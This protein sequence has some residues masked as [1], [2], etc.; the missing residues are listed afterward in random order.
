MKLARLINFAR[1]YRKPLAFVSGLMVIE[2][3]VAL[4]LPWLAGEFA[5]SI[6]AQQAL[7]INTVLGGI[8]G[9][10]ALRSV[11]SYFRELLLVDTSATIIADI[12]QKIYDHIQSLPLGY[13]RARRQ[14]DILSFAVY[15]A[16]EIS[17]Y[18]T[19]TVTSIVPNLLAALGAVIIMAAIDP[20]LAGI[21]L[22]LIPF[23]YIGLR[24]IGR[25]LRPLSVQVRDAYASLVS[26]V[27]E[28]FSMM[29]AIKAYTRE[30]TSSADHLERAQSLRLLEIQQGR[31]NAL[32][33][34][35][36]QF[37]ALATMLL[38][39]RLL[40]ER[41]SGGEMSVAEFV[42]FLLYAAYLTAPFSSLVDL[43]A[44]TQLTR[45]ALTR[46]GAVFDEV[47]EGAVSTTQLAPVKGDIRFEGLHLTYPGRHQALHGVDLHIRTGETI[48]ITGPNG[49]GKSTLINLLMRFDQPDQGRIL[50]DGTDIANVELKSLRSQIALVSQSVHLFHASLR[51]NI[52][53][54]LPNATDAAIEFAAR[55]AQA[56]D[57]AA[58]LPQGYETIIGDRGVRLSGGQAQ[59]I[60]LARALLKDPAILV[61]DEPTAMFDPDGEETFISAAR[62][63]F[64]DRTVILITHRPASLAL[65]DRIVSLAD[66]V[67][68]SD[69]KMT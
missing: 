65:A 40:G 24:L 55:R 21:V 5:A 37:A 69:R 49:V 42:S 22:G 1:P 29:P 2:T 62:E 53:Y 15:E 45:G 14:G 41:V 33:S 6:L 28:N 57:F 30:G 27:E 67:V 61:L 60:A 35:V 58:G 31:I 64:C 19:Y 44:Q 4:I 51:D 39:L 26:V 59:R 12:R 63:A 54:G 13:F 23:Y 66:G 48:A 3:I 16:E 8:I 25:K 47:P 38:L 43:W 36:I 32:I 9:L 46:L 11:F 20:I 18:L 34:T 17:S 52:A 10:F 7:N 68:V 56:H 50:I